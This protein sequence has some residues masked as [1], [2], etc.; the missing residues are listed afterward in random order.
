MGSETQHSNAPVLH[1]PSLDPVHPAAVRRLRLISSRQ[2][3][4]IFART[5]ASYKKLGSA[6]ILEL[7]LDPVAAIHRAQSLMKGAGGDHVSRVEPEEAR[8]PGQLIRNLVRH[9]FGIV[10]LP[11]LTVG[12]GF[13]HDVVRIG[14]F[15]L[16]DDPRTAAAMR[17]LTFGDE[18]RAPHQSSG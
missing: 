17:I 11:R 18:L 7:D 8:Q 10:V 6:H 2:P 5:V 13:H 1:S 3:V 15:V 9:E 4:R 14:D 12:P 16:G